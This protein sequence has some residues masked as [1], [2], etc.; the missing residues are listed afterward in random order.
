MRCGPNFTLRV[1]AFSVITNLRMELFGALVQG[2]VQ[3]IILQEHEAAEVVRYIENLLP[4]LEH[5][6][7]IERYAWFLSRYYEV[8]H[9]EICI[10]SIDISIYNLY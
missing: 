7:F 1:G 4:L 5:S 6:E 9:R 2:Q 10:V 3:E 8:I